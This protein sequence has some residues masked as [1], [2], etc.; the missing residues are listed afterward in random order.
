MSERHALVV[1][2]KPERREE[3][4]ELHRAVWPEVEATLRECNVTNYTIF[5]FGEIL[6]AYYEYAGDDHEADMA[7]IGEDPVTRE[8]WTR[9]DPC[10]VRIA[11][12]R[13]PG[14]LWQPIDELWHLS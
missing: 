5:A 2:V 6:F 7:R 11:D 14:A 8:W 10:Q 9:T 1:G 4:L 3:Y 12:E 13:E